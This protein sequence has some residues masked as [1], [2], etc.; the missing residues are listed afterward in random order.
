[1]F[2]KQKS[3]ISAYFVL[4]NFKWNIN[5]YIYLIQQSMV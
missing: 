4:I 2:S 5:I 1:M 3:V